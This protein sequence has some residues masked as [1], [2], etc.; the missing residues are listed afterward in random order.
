MKVGKKRK[1][2]PDLTTDRDGVK[3]LVKK[4]QRTEM[5]V[6]RKSWSVQPWRTQQSDNHEHSDRRQQ[7]KQRRGGL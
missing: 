4:I 3:I 6:G 5:K 2:V 1:T 7:E